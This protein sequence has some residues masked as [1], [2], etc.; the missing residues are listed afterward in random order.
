[1]HHS[2]IAFERAMKPGF[3][4][5]QKMYAYMKYEEERD[6]GG[7]TSTGLTSKKRRTAKLLKTAY[8]MIIRASMLDPK[9]ASRDNVKH[10]VLRIV[11]EL[12]FV[13]DK[14]P[15]D[16]FSKTQS[17]RGNLKAYKT[18]SAASYAVQKLIAAKGIP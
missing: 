3:F 8:S 9:D 12:F 11:R 1:M 16:S 17:I 15:I 6:I 13:I 4:L 7:E 10:F 5:K 2:K 18:P 14:A